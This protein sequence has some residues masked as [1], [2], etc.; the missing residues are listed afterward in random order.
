MKTHIMPGR[1]WGTRSMH[2]GA[3]TYILGV[4]NF[5]PPYFF[6]STDLSRIFLGLKVCLIE[7]IS[8]EVFKSC[9]FLG[10]KF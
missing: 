3:P 10:R 5:P 8:I 6:G 9:I 2:D 4:E 1:G 7:E